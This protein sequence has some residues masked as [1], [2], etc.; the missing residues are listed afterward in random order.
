L[1]DREELESQA[2]TSQEVKL[3]RTLRE[4]SPPAAEEQRAEAETM[5]DTPPVLGIVLRE[6]EERLSESTLSN[7][8]PVPELDAASKERGAPPPT[9][10]TQFAVTPLTAAGVRRRIA[11]W[12]DHADASAAV[13]E[14]RATGEGEARGA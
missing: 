14:T 13:E 11:D 1:Q 2:E 3:R 9:V 5:I 4:M 7:R 12:D 6:R 10:T 8:I